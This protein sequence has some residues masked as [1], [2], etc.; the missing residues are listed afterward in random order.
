[1]EKKIYRLTGSIEPDGSLC[2]LRKELTVA[3]ESRTGIYIK[4][5]RGFEKAI[6]KKHV[7]TIIN[8]QGGNPTHELF[9]I[10]YSSFV[11]EDK[12]DYMESLIAGTL[13]SNIA[14]VKENADFVF[15]VV[16]NG[17]FGQMLKLAV[18]NKLDLTE[19]DE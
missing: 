1:M 12:V 9:P 3:S 14:A 13:V 7:N 16:G 11:Y 2:I 18:D 5:T 15:N 8:F 17:E 19:E 6:S 4:K 10:K